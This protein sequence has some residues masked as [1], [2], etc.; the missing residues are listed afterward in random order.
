MNRISSALIS[1]IVALSACHSPPSADS[2]ETETRLAV[3]TSSSISRDG[4]GR[5]K[6]NPETIEGIRGMRALVAARPGS[7]L[8]GGLLRDSLEARMGAIFEGCTMEGE[9]HLALHD[10]LVPLMKL[11]R[12]LPDSPEP[13]QLDSISA[14]LSL[15]DERFR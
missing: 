7:G 5:W 8:E 1:L 2:T 15:F 4:P 13:S 9:A 14:H 12:D 3:D 11:L 10:Y 6:A